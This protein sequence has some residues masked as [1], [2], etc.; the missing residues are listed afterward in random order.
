MNLIS[1]M[2]L[3]VMPEF[4]WVIIRD[5]M[6]GQELAAGYADDLLERSA[7]FL[8]NF[9]MVSYLATE[10]SFIINARRKEYNK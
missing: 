8:Q 4:T 6:S 1:F 3:M 5:P 2:R 7:L 10:E 9:D